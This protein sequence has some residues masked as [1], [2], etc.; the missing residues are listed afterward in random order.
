MYRLLAL[1]QYTPHTCGAAFADF[2]LL[3]ACFRFAL[4]AEASGSSA[5]AMLEAM[6][7]GLD[8]LEDR[9]SVAHGA[10]QRE[11]RSGDMLT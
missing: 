11:W 5:E 4:M 2:L 10:Q 3:F 9:L 6:E 7:R 8:L 1:H